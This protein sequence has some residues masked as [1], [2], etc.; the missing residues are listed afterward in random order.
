MYGLRLCRHLL[1]NNCFA[2]VLFGIALTI[3]HFKSDFEV[4]LSNLTVRIENLSN[5]EIS[6]MKRN[7]SFR[8]RFSNDGSCIGI[9]RTNEPVVT[10]CDPQQNDD[11]VFVN[12]KIKSVKLDLCL[13][14]DPVKSNVLVFLK[15]NEAPN[16]QLNSSRLVLQDKSSGANKCVFPDE[17]L[18]GHINITDAGCIE[19]SG[20]IEMLEET[21]FLKDRAA[22]MLPIPESSIGS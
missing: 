7:F 16:F 20:Q 13:G 3:L 15:C 4:E 17:N 2:L 18:G 10:F 14:S 5:P 1:S 9:S 11:F 19:D 6:D 22:L 8:I 12:G 21:E